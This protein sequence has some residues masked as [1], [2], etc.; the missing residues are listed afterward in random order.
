MPAEVLLLEGVAG[1]CCKLSAWLLM[2]P[3]LRLTNRR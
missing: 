2:D 3:R 1:P